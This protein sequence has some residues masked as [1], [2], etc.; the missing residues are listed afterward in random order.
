M[1]KNT[2]KKILMWR[3]MAPISSKMKKQANPKGDM[4]ETI[5][6]V[7]WSIV[8]MSMM[9][10]IEITGISERSTPNRHR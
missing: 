9:N 7:T 5:S 6:K 8:T 10:M 2:K 1:N 3:K 4:K